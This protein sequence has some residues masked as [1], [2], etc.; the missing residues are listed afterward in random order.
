[1]TK[2]EPNPKKEPSSNTK[3]LKKRDNKKAYKKNKNMVSIQ[4][5][6]WGL[7]LKV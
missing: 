2:I 6:V 3:Y 1:L 5:Q 4:S 7:N